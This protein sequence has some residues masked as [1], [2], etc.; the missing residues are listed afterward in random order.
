MS[1]Q[2]LDKKAAATPTPEVKEANP[3]VTPAKRVTD[4][5]RIP[6]SLRQQKLA[7]PDIEGYHLHYAVDNRVA[8]ML[9]A[10]YEYVGYDE[11]DLTN[12]DLAGD[13]GASG[14]SDLGSRVSLPA[15]DSVESGRLVL[16][17]IRNEWWNQDCERM[18]QENEKIAARIRG[19]NIGDSS[20]D[21]VS[22]K[23][24]KEGQELFIP[25]KKRRFN[26]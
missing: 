17:K 22:H 9:R 14:N 23:Y 12:V 4:E 10:G 19:G 7:V 26:R 21:H 24:L 2:V 16:M 1:E 13:R 6:M 8:R 5:T 11:V 15:G 20:A 18:E 3:S 25:R